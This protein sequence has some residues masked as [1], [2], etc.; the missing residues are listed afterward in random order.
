[1]SVVS[2]PRDG[3]SGT[4]RATTIVHTTY[5]GDGGGVL[6]IALSGQNLF[7]SG[8]GHVAVYELAGRYGS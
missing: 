1:M 4:H 2:K 5:S 8:G 6:P 7:V 3:W